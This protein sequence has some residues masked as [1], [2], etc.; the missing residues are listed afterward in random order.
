MTTY[1]AGLDL[2]KRYLT[3]C[4]LDSSGQVVREPRRLP[5]TL[6]LAE[7][8]TITRFRSSRELVA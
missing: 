2:H 3:L 1:F 8:G 7:L 5:P 6:L 4:V